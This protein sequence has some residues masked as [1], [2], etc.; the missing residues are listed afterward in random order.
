MIAVGQQIEF[1]G[2]VWTVQALDFCES[3]PLVK[4]YNESIGVAGFAV[5]ERTARR[6]HEVVARIKSDGTVDKFI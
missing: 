6:H 5:L 4:A 1:K 2:N 3:T